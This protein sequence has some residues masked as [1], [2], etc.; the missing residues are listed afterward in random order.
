MFLLP[1]ISCN[2]SPDRAE[3]AKNQFFVEILEREN[4]RSI[5]EDGFFEKNL[6]NPYPEVRRWSAIAL[7]RIGDPEALPLLCN[8]VRSGDAALRAASAFSIGVIE[9]RA[10]CEGSLDRS[11]PGAASELSKLLDDP[12]ITVRMRAVEALGKIGSPGE[13]AEITRR[14]EA[15]EERLTP[16]ESAYV[17]FS[18]T[19]LA[20]LHHRPAAPVLQKCAAMKDPDIQWRALEALTRL[21]AK[22]A[23]ALFVENLN[24]P[25]P[26][27][28]SHAAR[29]LG[30][31]E[32]PSLA[33]RLFPLLLPRREPEL[34]PVPPVVRIRALQALGELNNPSAV[35]HILR[36]LKADPIDDAHPAQMQFAIQAAR[37]MA[38]LRS[39]HSESVLLAAPLLSGRA[40]DRAAAAPGKL[41]KRD[42]ET[43]LRPE[44]ILTEIFRRTLAAN[45]KNS[46][47]AV[48]ETN[49]GD[50][51]IELFREDAPVTA[52]YFALMASGGTYNGMEF[53]PGMPPERIE[54][55]SGREASAARLIQNEVN[56]R[57][58]E[59]GSVGM[60]L[61]AGHSDIS[62]FFIALE[63]QPYLDGIHACFGRIISGMQVADKIVP[64]DRIERVTIKETVHFHDYH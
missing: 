3:L 23:G 33:E 27:V 48:L 24:N 2:R 45:R 63:P 54:T 5:G 44:R 64:G 46:T 58:F 56:M 26:I 38:R 41:L 34:I 35:L 31:M 22:T 8:A 47:I 19:A 6:S 49:R 51:E 62:R 21:R 7:G 18:I 43:S 17:Q 20:R 10:L 29:G 25:D 12:S 42:K 16:A 57:P 1:C 53:G 32:D 52:A 30:I 28:C 9:H 60:P 13:A 61:A 37:T 11:H 39:N 4:R 40:A 59:R 14:L 15:F 55:K 50:L 36:A